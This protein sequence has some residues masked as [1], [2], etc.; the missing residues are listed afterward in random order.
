MSPLSGGVL[1]AA[2]LVASPALWSSLDGT[3][4][5][6]VA[7]TRYLIAVG[8]CWALMSLVAEIALPSPGAVEVPQVP[9]EE[10]PDAET[11]ET[12]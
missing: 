4:P 5:L 1:A 7:L 9:A 11:V 2:T 8:I 10:K 12:P 6:D 3:M